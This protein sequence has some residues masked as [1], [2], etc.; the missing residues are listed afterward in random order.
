MAHLNVGS[1][2]PVDVAGRKNKYP[3]FLTEVSQRT[4]SLIAFWQNVGFVHG[5]LNTDNM[6]ILGETID[7]G[8]VSCNLLL[9]QSFGA[10]GVPWAISNIL[11]VD[12]VL[13]QF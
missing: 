4:G 12:H 6:S 7:Y 8:Y 1:P 5:V 11:S 9:F 10:C 2:T 13:V 3:E